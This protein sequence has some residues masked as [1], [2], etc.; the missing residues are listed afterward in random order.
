MGAL[1]DDM[2]NLSRVTRSAMTRHDVDL[3]RLVRAELATLSREDPERKVELDIAEGLFA[4]C[5]ERLLRIALEN[6]LNN[7]WK[8]TS[9]RACAHIAFGTTGQRDGLT[10]YFVRDDGAGFDMAFADKLFT[11]F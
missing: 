8:F 1:I 6:L 4:S 11:P 2:I 5:D 3:S 10:V 7:A 9:K